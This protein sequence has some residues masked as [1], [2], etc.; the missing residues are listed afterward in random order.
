MHRDRDS[1]KPIAPEAWRALRRTANEEIE[2]VF[3]SDQASAA[4]RRVSF[5]CECLH[6]DCIVPVMATTADFRHV[7]RAPDSRYLVAP[8]HERDEDRI[9]ERHETFVV[10]G[11]VEPQP[12][13]H[14]AAG[15][16]TP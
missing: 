10:V 8:G 7:R 11:D 6:V 1:G 15:S 3:G 5:V 13:V 12:L 9:V 4:N 16:R 14:G 2:R